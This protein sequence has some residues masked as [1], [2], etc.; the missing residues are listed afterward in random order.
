MRP[1]SIITRRSTLAMWQANYIRS[2]LLHFHPQLDIKIIPIQTLGDKWLET[3]LQNIG[4]KGLF[5]RELEQALLTHEA[6]LAV[7]SL[8]DVPADFP[9]G[10]GLGAICQRDDPFDAWICPKGFTLENIPP[11]ASVGTSSLR[12]I[13]QLTAQRPDLQYAPLRG[14]IDT[15]LKYCLDGKWDAIVLAVAGLS[16]LNLQHHI[17]TIFTPEVMLPAVGQGALAV[18]CRLDDENTRALLSRLDDPLTRVC[19]EAERAMNFALGGNCQIPVAGFAEYINDGLQLT[20]LVA[21]QAQSRIIRSQRTHSALYPI[22]L[23]EEVALDL[24]DQGADE[25]IAQY[26]A[27]DVDS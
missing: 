10:L 3:P 5:V 27:R 2:Q 11:G 8:K 6:D 20:A 13:A 9:D 26:S 25:I 16:R 24:R 12:R 4:G 19:I 17:T 18:E 14:N 15:R 1:L 21:D 23:G 7:H 22:E